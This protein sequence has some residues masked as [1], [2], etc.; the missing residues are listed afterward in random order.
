MTKFYDYLYYAIYKFYSPK[1]KGAATS[2][3]MI[4]EGLQAANVLSGLIFISICISSKR[5]VNAT[6][7]VSVVLFFMIINYICYI[8]KEKVNIEDLG[9]EWQRK[10][11]AQKVRIRALRFLYIALSVVAF[12]GLA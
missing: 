1:E 12:F 8:Y 6:I 4:T 9:D 5:Y 7:F 10:T 2:A 3:A 11:D